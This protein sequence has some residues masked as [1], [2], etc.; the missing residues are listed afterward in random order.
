MLLHDLSLVCAKKIAIRELRHSMGLAGIARMTPATRFTKSSAP[1]RSF[2]HCPALSHSTQQVYRRIIERIRERHGKNPIKLLETRQIRKFAS[3][4]QKPTAPCSRRILRIEINRF[5]AA[6]TNWL[7]S[8][9]GSGANFWT[10]IQALAADN[11]PLQMSLFDERDMTEISSPE[12][13]L[14]V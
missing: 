6:T 8:A 14:G 12:P 11:G 5:A 1:S 2:S 7:S 9:R 3:E 10:A 4:I 13:R